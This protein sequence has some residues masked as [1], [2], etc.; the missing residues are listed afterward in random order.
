M[1]KEVYCWGA[2]YYKEVKISKESLKTKKIPKRILNSN[3]E[4]E[5]FG[6]GGQFAYCFS[7]YR[8]ENISNFNEDQ[9]ESS[10]PI[11]LLSVPD[12]P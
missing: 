2:D 6:A 8:D 11:R 4:V 7:K 9:L 3:D 10:N 1:N 5:N 12:V